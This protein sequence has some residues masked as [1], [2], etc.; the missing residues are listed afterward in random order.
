MRALAKKPSD[1]PQSMRDFF[2]EFTLGNVRSSLLGRSV[3]PSAPELGVPATPPPPRPPSYIPP[4]AAVP[5]ETIDGPTRVGGGTV[6]ID[7]SGVRTA[8]GPGPAP[9]THVESGGAP[10]PPHHPATVLGQGGAPGPGTGSDRPPPQAAF[11]APPAMPMPTPGPTRIDVVPPTVREPVPA[12]VR[13][14]KGRGVLIASSIAGALLVAMAIV[15]VVR[16]VWKNEAGGR[17]GPAGSAIATA[18]TP[19]PPLPTSTAPAT[20]AVTTP[21]PPATPALPTAPPTALPVNPTAASDP[22]RLCIQHSLA[23]QCQEALKFRKLCPDSHPNHRDAH[24][25]FDLHCKQ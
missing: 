17:T 5:G 6:V 9:P 25:T 15:M 14:T 13:E 7:A 3:L 23:D 24:I 19:T 12:T 8:Q 20:G 10:M 4:P 2:S 22:C 18:R 11:A 1:R 21:S 16:V